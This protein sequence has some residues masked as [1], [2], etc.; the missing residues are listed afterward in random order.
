MGTPEKIFSGNSVF[1]LT[2]AISIII[3]INYAYIDLVF[4]IKPYFSFGG[5]G[6]FLT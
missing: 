3:F 2:F 1:Q 4:T 6:T 5:F